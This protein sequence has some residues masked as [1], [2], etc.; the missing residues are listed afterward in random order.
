[1]ICIDT[2]LGTIESYTQ[3]LYFP[4][5][6]SSLA[7]KNGWPQLYNQFLANVVHNDLQSHVVPLPQ[8]S[9]I[10][11]RMVKELAI[12]PEL[13]YLDASHDY[14]DVKQDLALAWECLSEDGVLFGD[15]YITWPGVTRAV[16]EFCLERNLTVMGC[17]S[18]FAVARR[19]N[20][21][22]FLG[23]KNLFLPDG[24]CGS[25]KICRPTL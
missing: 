3:R 14:N 19:G 8:T 23:E 9:L 2:F 17:P 10:G 13:I 22:E 5:L 25:M 7:L 15:D 4:M 21:A 6:Y 1:M 18:K 24:S 16:D 11:L 12:Q 20:I